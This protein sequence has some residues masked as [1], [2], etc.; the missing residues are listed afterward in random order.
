MDIDQSCKVSTILY[1]LITTLE[2]VV[3]REISNLPF[4]KNNTSIKNN[5]SGS[6]LYNPP[7]IQPNESFP[8]AGGYGIYR[9]MENNRY[10]DFKQ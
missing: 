2:Y 10:L 6:C 4:A 8:V 3:S 9:S 7:L 5:P 1:K